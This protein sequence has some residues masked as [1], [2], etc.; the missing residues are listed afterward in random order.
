MKK[1]VPVS[2]WFPCDKVIPDV[3][4][5]TSFLVTCREWNIFEGTWGERE[6]RIVSYS[7]KAKA[8]NTKSDIKIEA[9]LPLPEIYNK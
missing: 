5:E 7:P 8:W 3:K 6:I 9:W 2:A 1:T 4:Q